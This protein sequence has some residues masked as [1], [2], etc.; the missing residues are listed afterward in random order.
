[1]PLELDPKVGRSTVF[2]KINLFTKLEFQFED[3][4][5]LRSLFVCFR[6]ERGGIEVH[7]SPGT[8]PT[9]A[10]FKCG[11]EF[12]LNS[13]RSSGRYWGANPVSENDQ[14]YMVFI[15]THISVNVGLDGLALNTWRDLQLPALAY[16]FTAD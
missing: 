16:Q 15:R 14:H 12:V 4:V 8:S 6:H 9:I 13:G 10:A 11:G 1:M 3:G 5:R 7:H 2:A